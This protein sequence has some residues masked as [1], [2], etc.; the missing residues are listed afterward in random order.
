MR[1]TRNCSNFY[2]IFLIVH[3]IVSIIVIEKVPLEIYP[4][5]CGVPLMTSQNL[6]MN[7]TPFEEGPYLDRR[8][9]HLLI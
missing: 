1:S 4:A 5:I 9:P 6:K 8:K 7:D 2:L 3:E